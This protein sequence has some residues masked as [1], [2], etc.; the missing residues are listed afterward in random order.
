MLLRPPR[1]LT[2][3]ATTTVAAGDS[4]GTLEMVAPLPS[5]RGLRPLHALLSARQ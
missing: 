5:T 1:P 3:A 4:P 2:S